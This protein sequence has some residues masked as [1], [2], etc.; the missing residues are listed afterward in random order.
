MDYQS[1][2]KK[3]VNQLKAENR[4]R[5]FANLERKAGEHPHAIWHSDSGPKDVIIW[6][7]NDYLGMG[8]SKKSIK[9]MTDSV[10]NHG[11]ELVVR[12]I[13]QALAILLFLWKMNLQH[14]TAKSVPLYLHQATLQMKPV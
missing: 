4:Y 2:F 8:Q 7:S 6:C 1:L 10:N 12:A 5:V 11:T 9:A 14:Y 3:H 13:F